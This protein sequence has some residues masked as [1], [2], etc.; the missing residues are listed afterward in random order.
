[1]GDNSRRPHAVLERESRI[2]KADKM[3]TLLPEFD[4]SRCTRILEI[5]C[6]SG[7][8]ASRLSEIAPQAEVHAVDVSDNRIESS[9]FTFA[10]V[11]GTQLPF[12]DNHFDLV[13]SNHVI[14]HVGDRSEQVKHLR[15]IARTL[16]PSGI[17][18]L[19][20][21]NKWRLVE[22]HY[23]LPFL[24][25]LPQKI[26]DLWI[27]ILRRGAFYDCVPLSSRSAVRLFDESGVYQRDITIAALRATLEIEHA[28][29]VV[30][31]LVRNHV[32]DWMLQLSK[33]VIPTLIYLLR[34]NNS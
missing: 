34:K 28:E 5:G 8:I 29:S 10:I 32:P 16:S 4:F 14:E 21:P 22:P 15:E 24:S 31:K 12:P 25:W 33:P 26:A 11:E 13:I 7:V 20:V 2:S 18:Y 23:R 27:R 19:A 6:G 9:G 17:G 3:V 1:M 30:T